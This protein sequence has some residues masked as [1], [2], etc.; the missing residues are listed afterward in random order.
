MRLRR[1]LVWVNGYDL[2]SGKGT[3]GAERRHRKNIRR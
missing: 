2:D 3:V 1:S